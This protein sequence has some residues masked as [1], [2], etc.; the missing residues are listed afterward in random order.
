MAQ[1]QSLRLE[2][3]APVPMRDGTILRADIYLPD[4]PRPCP[5]LV[6]RT[7]Y[8]KAVHATRN[9]YM[10]PLR[11]ARAGY[12]VV[13]QDCRGTG[14]SEGDLYPFRF[15]PD[16][17]YDTVEWAAAQA[18]CDGNVGMYGASY[19]G[20]T[21]LAAA[22]T[23][24][25]HL[26]AICPGQVSPWL[27]PTKDGVFALQANLRWYLNQSL[28]ALGK[29]GWPPERSRP[30]AGQL[31]DMIA[32]LEK[33]CD[34]LPLVEAP[35]VRVAGLPLHP[36]YREWL[37]HIDD[38]AYWRE[39][40]CPIPLD[41]IAVP[42]LLF[43]GWYDFQES[44]V[45][46]N[47]RRI[48]AEA[49]KKARE[50]IKLVV[51][52]WI[53]GCELLNTVDELDFGVA[54]SGAAVDLTGT[55]IRWFDHWLKGIQN[56]I[57]EEPRVRL[58]VMGENTWREEDE[59]PLARTRFTP[60][61][62]HSGGRANSLSGDGLLSQ[63]PPSAEESDV[64]L[65]DPRNPVPSKV[66]APLSAPYAFEVQ[67]Q[68]EIEARPDVLVYTTDP[69]LCDTEV[70]GPVEV[71]LWAATSVVDTDFTVKL[72]DVYPEGRALNLTENILR[73]RYREGLSPK[74]I[75]PGRIYEYSI[76]L[77]ETSNLFRRGH[78]I[79][80]EVSSSSF[81][82]YDRNLNTGRAIGQDAELNVAVQRVF[83]D[84][85]HPSRLILPVIPRS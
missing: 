32:H 34:F 69:L 50:N 22:I 10:N 38:E 37:D 6:I 4:T 46:A 41:R 76:S 67:D 47:Y 71:R 40:N 52:P 35:A 62:F 59:W 3:D 12:A 30:A 73:V 70:T 23:R 75:E 45:F 33:Q 9:G 44:G 85:E 39:L 55:H 84:S 31:L 1:Q 20:F 49:A 15:E 28:N 72:V 42:T 74:L 36:F 57:M 80:L 27:P 5:A 56:G 60:F 14:A 66:N 18:W 19:L 21:Q 82:R 29:A 58:F 53:H 25:P 64:F 2:A 24:P 16:D 61:Y 79:R 54:A 77:K 68:R 63:E 43:T 26:R 11:V 48:R 17:G 13:V 7:P 51:G 78:R 81:P 65:Y 83:H 8:L